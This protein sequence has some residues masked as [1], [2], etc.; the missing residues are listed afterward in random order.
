MA[1]RRF[2]S[3]FAAACASRSAR[4]PSNQGRRRSYT[5][6]QIRR[7]KPRSLPTIVRGCRR[8]AGRSVRAEVVGGLPDRVRAGT[9]AGRRGGAGAPRR[10]ARPRPQRLAARLQRCLLRGAHRKRRRRLRAPRPG[11]RARSGARAK[12]R[13]ARRGFR[14]AA[15]GPTLATANG[16]VTLRAA[17]RVA[18]AHSGPADGCAL[19][20]AR[21][22]LTR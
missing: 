19:V 11:G 20:S 8:K 6:R 7:E 15:I 22:S 1:T 13:C 4:R 9:R 18:S 21:H 16:C 12:A 3:S 5:C 2:T 10:G 17:A 14:G